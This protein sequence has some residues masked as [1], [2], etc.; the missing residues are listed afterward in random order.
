MKE[1]YIGRSGLIVGEPTIPEQIRMGHGNEACYKAMLWS[2]TDHANEEQIDALKRI[3]PFSKFGN[4]IIAGGEHKFEQDVM[5]AE[6]EESTPFQPL[7]DLLE[8]YMF[9][10]YGQRGTLKQREKCVQRETSPG[11]GDWV[12]LDW[13]SSYLPSAK[14]LWRNPQFRPYW[15]HQRTLYL[16]DFSTI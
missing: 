8:E 13:H 7:V 11:T 3:P 1:L 10:E 14:P 2:K 12:H 16:K 5:K 6:E 4:N 15:P 9:A